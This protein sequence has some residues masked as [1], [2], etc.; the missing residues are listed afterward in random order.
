MVTAEVLKSVPLFAT[1]PEEQL[2]TLASCVTV[3]KYPRSTFILR[4]G[5]D[6]IYRFLRLKVF[7]TATRVSAAARIA[8]PMDLDYLNASKEQLIAA[9]QRLEAEGLATLEKGFAAP[10]A[11]P[12]STPHHSGAQDTVDGGW[13]GRPPPGGGPGLLTGLTEV[14]T[15]AVRAQPGAA[16][17]AGAVV[18]S[19]F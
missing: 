6:D 5:E 15:G 2:A 7:W 1:L 13:R 17:A 9:A 12:Y 8:D 3:R 18:S 14:M 10:S 11:P 16:R 4:A 19:R